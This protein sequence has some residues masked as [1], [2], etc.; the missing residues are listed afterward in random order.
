MWNAD[1]EPFGQTTITT[2]TV[3]NNLRFPGQYFDGKTGLHYNYFRDYD[4]GIGR[5][6]ESDPVLAPSTF[7]EEDFFEVIPFLL[8]IP[9]FDGHSYEYVTE[10]P[11]TFSDELGLGALG[12]IKCFYYSYKIAKFGEECQKECPDDIEGAA[13]F[14]ER[15]TDTGYL[16]AALLSCTCEKAGKELCSHWVKSCAEGVIS[17]PR[18]PRR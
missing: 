18:T 12:A 15:Y 4:P 6:I 8:T 11:I 1:Y 9:G 16:S 17:M 2:E 5:Y 14:I 7:L 13:R 3:I 10:N